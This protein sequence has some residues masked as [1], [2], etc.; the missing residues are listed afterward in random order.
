MNKVVLDTETDGFLDTLTMMSVAWTYDTVR[1][2]WKEWTEGTVTELVGYLN[3]FDIMVG[4]N[5]YG[6]DKP[7]LEKITGLTLTANLFDTLVASRLR[8]P[9]ILGGHSLRAWGKRLGVL[10]GTVTEG[11][12]DDEIAQVY[13]VY[14]PELSVYC[15]DDVK[16]TVALLERLMQHYN[17]EDINFN[18][19]DWERWKV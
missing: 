6:F 15:Y 1:E 12:D 17:L 10:K 8:N 13:G 18:P 19:I 11:E 9:D 14:T 2:E 3:T 7:A 16:V 5:V 4:H